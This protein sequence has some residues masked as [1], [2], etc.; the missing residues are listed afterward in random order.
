MAEAK[1]FHEAAPRMV[2]CGPLSAVVALLAVTALACGGGRDGSSARDA[3]GGDA[4]AA[5][6]VLE[7]TIGAGNV[8]SQ[9]HTF[10]DIL[11]IAVAGDNTIWVLDGS[12]TPGV[13]QSPRLRQFTADG[14]FLREV[15]RAGAGP[16]EFAAPYA[17]AVLGGDRVAVRDYSRRG[18]IAVFHADGGLDT[19]LSLGNTLNWPFNGRSPIQVDTSGVMWLPF[20]GR[21]GPEQGPVRFLRVRPD[22]AILDTV[23]VPVV[24]EVERV[25]LSVTRTL[26]GGR[27]S[28]RGFPFPNQPNGIWAWSPFGNFVVARTDE[29]RIHVLLPP[30]HSG[31]AAG[32]ADSN[33]AAPVR[34]ISR[35]VAPVA[36]SDAERA[37]SRERL[38]RDIASAE[39]AGD[40]QV[41]PLPS[42]KPPMNWIEYSDDRRL[43]VNV[44]L[45]SVF[46]DGVWT[47]TRAWDVFDVN[48]RYQ[49]RIVLPAAFTLEVLRGDSMWGV[50]RDSL[51]TE[52]VRRY[53]VVWH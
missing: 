22:G 14:N 20:R 52:S 49:G 31:I 29:Y 24:P 7:V 43:M 33:V 41:P 25:E 53:R 50:Y 4:A 11:D 12:N 37:A 34:S 30:S 32:R 46:V 51:D 39:G 8:E 18:E 38:L 23:A 47:E 27:T 28:G 17:L 26:P 9:D 40:L 42:S 35:T 36:V 3:G 45:P 19:V 2:T 21:P 6:L 48:E 10:A 5:Q 44:P 13:Q 1:R 15:S 16:G